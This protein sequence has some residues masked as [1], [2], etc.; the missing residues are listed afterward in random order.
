MV[1]ALW[2]TFNVLKDEGKRWG[3][4][5]VGLLFGYCIAH[6]GWVSIGPNH[7]AYAFVVQLGFTFTGFLLGPGLVDIY[8]PRYRVRVNEVR[9]Y[10]RL[11]SGLFLRMLKAIGWNRVV[12]KMRRM[13]SDAA[14]PR[15]FL[16]NTELSETGHLIGLLATAMLTITAGLFSYPIGAGQ[17]FFI[18]FLM[19]GY[20]IMTQRLGRFRVIGA[21]ETLREADK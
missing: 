1:Y 6:S 18:G 4:T 19:H 9:I 16:R 15:Q 11:G 10:A 14:A 7:L 5:A 13:E 3:L 8:R 21:R 12:E 20:P 2:N 17:I